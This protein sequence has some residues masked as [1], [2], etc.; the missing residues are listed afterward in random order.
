[1]LADAERQLISALAEFQA[2]DGGGRCLGDLGL[3]LTFSSIDRGVIGELRH[4]SGGRISSGPVPVMGNDYQAAARIARALVC[5]LIDPPAVVTTV[6]SPVADPA[7]AAD[8]SP[9]PQPRRRGRPPKNRQQGGDDPAIPPG[10]E[11]A[12]ASTT[13]PP[14]VIAD[15]QRSISKP[16]PDGTVCDFIVGV[17]HDNPAPA[18]T[19]H[20][21][22]TPTAEA[23]AA[24][25]P[26]GA[27]FE[28]R[29]QA[30]L[31]RLAELYAAGHTDSV[32]S[33]AE[34]FR[35]TFPAQFEANPAL[36]FAS[37]V[38]T[39]EHLMWVASQLS[40]FPLQGA[41]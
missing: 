31:T 8:P 21:P 32:Q 1:M 40:T 6:P 7:T 37:A 9:D 39:E 4:A 26:V 23:P 41:T 28:S 12:A 36:P 22:C 25:A 38:T 11:P 30:A 5:G 29:R 34:R 33:L 17:K 2:A 35:T 24:P 14:E 20:E 18:E 10:P 27:D 19:V 16:L 13:V 15:I 3:A